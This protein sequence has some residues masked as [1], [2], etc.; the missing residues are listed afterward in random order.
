MTSE[1]SKVRVLDV[2]SDGVASAVGLVTKPDRLRL[3]IFNSL[4][5]PPITT[6]FYLQPT[7]NLVSAS[8]LTRLLL[9]LSHF[10]PWVVMVECAWRSTLAQANY[11]D[12]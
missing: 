7:E 9:L 8:T 2:G 11:Y 1:G 5:Q 3:H 4:F 12:S 6:R 10:L